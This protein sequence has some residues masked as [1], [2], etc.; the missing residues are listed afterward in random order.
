M[1]SRIFVPRR[2]ALSHVPPS[3]IDSSDPFFLTICIDRS[4]DTIL[5]KPPVAEPLLHSVRFYNRVHRWHVSI[6][7]AMPDHVHMIASFPD[8]PGMTSTVRSWKRYTAR[9]LGVGWQRNFFDHRIRNALLASTKGRIHLDE[10]GPCGSCRMSQPMA[11]VR[12]HTAT[13]ALIA[14]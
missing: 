5:T 1:A 13:G 8:D 2:R 7:V 3:G 10:P 11:M 14:G 4:S 9:E 12:H 6:F